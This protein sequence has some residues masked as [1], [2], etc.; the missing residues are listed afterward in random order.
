MSFTY[1]WPR[2]FSSTS[3]VQR[4]QAGMKVAYAVVHIMLKKCLP[5]WLALL[6][7]QTQLKNSYTG[8]WLQAHQGDALNGAMFRCVERK[9]AQLVFQVG[10]VECKEGFVFLKVVEERRRAAV[11]LYDFL[12]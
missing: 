3:Q 4:T 9:A 12:D 10:T 2:T 6:S 5:I 7:L 11:A 8:F 1:L